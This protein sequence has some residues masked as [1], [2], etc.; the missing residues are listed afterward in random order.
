MNISFAGTF[1]LREKRSSSKFASTDVLLIKNRRF[2]STCV[3]N[4]K[5]ICCIMK[6]KTEFKILPIFYIN[7]Y[8]FVNQVG[9]IFFLIILI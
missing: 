8:K 4:I 7:N 2:S 5:I 1:S 6:K 9:V 3:G